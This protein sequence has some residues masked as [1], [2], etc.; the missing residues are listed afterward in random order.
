ME[1]QIQSQ[2][3]INALSEKIAAITV[4]LETTKLALKQTQ[5]I[6]DHATRL[7]REGI[8]ANSVLAEEI[9]IADQEENE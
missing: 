3:L 5:E 9:S 7:L 4:E 1:I 6:A 8:E 2:E